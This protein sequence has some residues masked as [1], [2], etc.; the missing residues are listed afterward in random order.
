[1]IT[2][3]A[4]DKDKPN[5]PELKVGEY[6]A[7]EGNVYRVMDNGKYVNIVTGRSL[8]F[9]NPGVQ[10]FCHRVGVEYKITLATV[11]S[12][13]DCLAMK[14]FGDLEIGD[15]F[16]SGHDV[17][18]RDDINVYRNVLDQTVRGGGYFRREG[19]L[20]CNVEIVTRF[21]D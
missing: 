16:I 13:R 3:N 11:P 18:V 19:T 20:M 14:F 9:A 5:V 4:L 21:L 2:L 10:K 15:T 7:T 17:F 12:F 1:M 8:L 6:F